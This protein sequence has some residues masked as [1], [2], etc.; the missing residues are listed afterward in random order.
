MNRI[1]VFLI[2]VLFLVLLRT[3]SG[4]KNR[5]GPAEKLDSTVSQSAESVTV[6]VLR[7]VD[8]DTLLLTTRERVRLLGVDTPETKKEG[9]PVQSYGLE[10]AEFT[11]QFCEGKT[12]TLVFDRERFDKYHRLLA[13]VFVG[14]R[15][16]NEELILNGLSPAVLQY[17]LR[18]DMKSRF[19]QAERIAKANRRGLWS[20]QAGSRSVERSPEFSPPPA[21][22]VPQTRD[23]EQDA[24]YL[25]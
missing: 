7:V 20:T 6:S 25:Q 21:E 1:S 12:V 19:Q 18:S 4:T 23:I 5:I 15:C 13:F 3:W 11:R 16:L 10:A 17:P 22:T 14:D 24:P 2:C 9:T 8:G